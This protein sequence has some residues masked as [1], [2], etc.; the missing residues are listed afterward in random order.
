MFSRRTDWNLEPNSLTIA[1]QEA[2][3]AG[4]RIIDLTISNPTRAEIKYNESAIL[5]ALSS[6]ESLEYDP[7][8]KG[9]RSAR[10]AVAA[11]Y[12]PTIDPEYVILTTSTSEGYSFV[13][14]LLCNPGDEILVPKPSYPLFDFLAELQDVNL[15]PYSLIYDHG[16]QIDFHSLET[17]ITP[18]SRA[19]VLVH[20]NNPTGSYVSADERRE[21]NEICQRQGLALII[22]EVFLDYAH[23]KPQPTFATNRHALSF[24]LSGISKISALPQMKLAWIAVSGPPAEVAPAMQRLEIISDTYLSLNAPIQLAAPILL[25]QRKA[26]QP[27]LMQ[28]VLANLA[29][30]ERQLAAQKS[31]ARLEVQGGWYAVLRIPV[32]RADEDFAVELLRR[33]GVLVHPGHFYDFVSDGYIVLSLIATEE[34]FRN[35]VSS[36]LQFANM[37]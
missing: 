31:C 19:I 13:F 33:S 37:L 36:A 5:N 22:D 16:W 21:L 15:A 29:D 30:L 10:E 6:P 28:R 4:K 20:P 3:A 14:R 35:G 17:A 1:H 24:T 8:P 26:I 25:D 18:K 34:E 12:T 23:S 2:L 27:Q 9:L 11:Y 32:I 7:Q